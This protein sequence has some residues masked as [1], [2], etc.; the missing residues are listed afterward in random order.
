[1]KKLTLCILAMAAFASCKKESPVSSKNNTDGRPLVTTDVPFAAATAFNNLFTRSTGGEWT[2]SDI[3]Y[4]IPL[5]NGQVFWPMGDTF[6]DPVNPADATHPTRYH[7]NPGLLSS[8]IVVTNGQGTTA[9]SYYATLYNISGGFPVPYYPPVSGTIRRWAKDGVYY[10]NKIYT[11]IFVNQQGPG[12]P[13]DIQTVR[14]DWAVINYP[15]YT[16][17]SISVGSTSTSVI[18]GSSV[19]KEGNYIYIYGTE[20]THPTPSTTVNYMHIAR[21]S[22]ITGGAWKYYKGGTT[23]NTTQ[24]GSYRLKGTGSVD[25][26][27]ISTEYKIFKSG[28][29]FYLIVQDPFFLGPNIFRYKA[30]SVTGPFTNKLKLFSAPLPSGTNFNGTPWTSPVDT[31]NYDAKAHPEFKRNSTSTDLLISYDVNNMDISRV[32]ANADLYRPYFYWVSNWQ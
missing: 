22:T 27:D 29:T 26:T 23:W 11:T 30:T 10:N 13:L 24:A 14:T 3:A 9:P 20:V 12:G 18:Y 25:L 15:A 21:V 19:M 32:I 4:S 17:Q 31:W 1:M 7:T 6:I 5:P 28:S 8:S 2:G 16:V